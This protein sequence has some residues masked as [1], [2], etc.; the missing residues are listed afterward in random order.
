MFAPKKPTLTTPTHEA[1][2]S[3]ESARSELAGKPPSVAGTQWSDYNHNVAGLVLVAMAIVGLLSYVRG[4]GWARLWPFG[5]VA[6]SVFLFFRS[7]AETWPLGPVGFWDSL[8]ADTEVLQHRV[9]TVLAFALG[10]IEMRSRA[11]SF[12]RRRVRYLFPV[13]CAVGGILLVTHAHTPFEIKRDYLIQST[14]LAMGL[15]ALV[16]A[17]GRWLE[18]RFADAQMV[19]ESKVAGIVAVAAMLLIGLILVFYR[20]PM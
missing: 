9:A 19:R 20:E 14:H 8:L 12:T 4:F 11:L 3:D 18:L 16:M 17:A 13:L 2:L 15:L 1:Y 10:A 7:D 6:L 5:F